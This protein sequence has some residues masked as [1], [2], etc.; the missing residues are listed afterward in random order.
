MGALV[1]HA[2]SVWGW[3][4]GGVR[5]IGDRVGRSPQRL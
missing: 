4:G 2:M 5:K 3:L 1:G